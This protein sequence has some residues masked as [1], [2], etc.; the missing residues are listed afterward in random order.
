MRSERRGSR[1]RVES[2]RVETPA[3]TGEKDLDDQDEPVLLYA[4]SL[5]DR[6]PQV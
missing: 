6:F 2:W 4:G 5:Q 1:G 3:V